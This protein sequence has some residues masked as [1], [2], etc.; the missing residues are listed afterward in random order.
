L[1]GIR[2]KRSRIELY[3]HILKTCSD[4]KVHNRSFLNS[5]LL[6]SFA[7]LNEYIFNL[8]EL[9]LLEIANYNKSVRTTLKGKEF[10]KKFD[11]LTNQ[12]K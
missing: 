4:T 2:N 1:T 10:V 3:Y 12:V 11:Y 6:V 8:N 9:G 7:Q 5:K